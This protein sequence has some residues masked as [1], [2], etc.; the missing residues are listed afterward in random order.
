MEV[1][2]DAGVATRIGPESC[3][4]AGNGGGEALTGGRAGR[5]LSREITFWIGEPRLWSEAEGSTRGV[6]MARRF[7]SP[8]G[9]RPRACTQASRTGTGR[10]HDRPGEDASQVR[11]ILGDRGR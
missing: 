6:V 9:R 7:R 2:Y 8:R 4:V 5:P 10:A 11:A 3:T 1:P